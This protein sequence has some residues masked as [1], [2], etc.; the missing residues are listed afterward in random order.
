M[1]DCQAEMP[2]YRC[3]KEVWAL[4]I[5]TVT[6]QFIKSEESKTGVI[7]DG[8]VLTFEEPGYAPVH[9]DAQWTEKFDPQPGQYLVTYKD[10]YTSVSP[11]AAFEEGYS[12]IIPQ[13]FVMP[14]PEEPD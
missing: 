4:K 12:R 7:P 14:C 11:A 5:K 3:H 13:P 6:L 10:G 1:S 8:A 2:K 9:C